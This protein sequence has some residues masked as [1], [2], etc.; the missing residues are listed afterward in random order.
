[1]GN[2]EQIISFGMLLNLAQKYNHGQNINKLELQAIIESCKCS[3]DRDIDN[4]S[5]LTTEQKE[6]RKQLFSNMADV[7]K[8]Y[9]EQLLRDE[10]KLNE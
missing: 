3:H 5:S 8:D 10:Y 9:I 6:K 7:A 4:N 1:M 2:L